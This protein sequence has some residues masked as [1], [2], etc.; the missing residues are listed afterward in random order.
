MTTTA[1]NT[2]QPTE[3]RRMLANP[4]YAALLTHNDQVIGEGTWPAVI[5]VDDHRATR[6]ILDDP[7]RHAAR[8][9]E[10]SPFLVGVATCGLCTEPT[11]IYST[12]SRDRARYYYCSTKRHLS[13]AADPI[14]EYV[15]DALL[16]RL[17]RTPTADLLDPVDPTVVSSLRTDE[18]KIRARLDGVADA[19]AARDVDEL[20]LRRAS[21]RLRADLEKVT[22]ELT[23]LSRRPAVAA[24]LEHD[25]LETGWHTTPRDAQRAILDSLARITVH[26]P[27]RGARRF[28]PDTIQIDWT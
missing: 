6:A 22:A 24:L 21:T 26:S 23:G 11:A 10:T 19:Y 25:N 17:A 20:Q 18:T 13:R 9:K 4:R 15:T 2:W 5:T 16:D 28:N 8:P 27:G 14:E 12:R 3:T 7:T 1:G